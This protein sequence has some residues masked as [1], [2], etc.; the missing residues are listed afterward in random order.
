MGVCPADSRGVDADTVYK[1]PFLRENW[2][3]TEQGKLYK[4]NREQAI[5]LA[6]AAG[7]KYI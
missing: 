1:N 7:I 2:N 3:L 5:A 6:K 4:G